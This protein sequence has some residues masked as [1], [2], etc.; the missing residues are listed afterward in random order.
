[1]IIGF[2]LAALIFCGASVFCF[3]KANYCAC[4]QAGQCDNPVNHYWLGAI[5]SALIALL[6][7][8]VALHSEKGS[9]LWLVLM[10]SCFSGALLSARQSAKRRCDK[11]STKSASALS[12]NEPN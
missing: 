6:L 1:M 10:A 4:T 9:I 3:C 11:S 7:C 8:S 2:I 5:L 12:T